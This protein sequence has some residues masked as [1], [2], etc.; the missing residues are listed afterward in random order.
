LAKKGKLQSK[1][2]NYPSNVLSL[3]AHSTSRLTAKIGQCFP[4]TSCQVVLDC[5]RIN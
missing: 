2:P 3:F 5:Q 1:F 4:I